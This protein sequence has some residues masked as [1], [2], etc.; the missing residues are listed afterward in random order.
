MF[1]IYRRAIASLIQERRRAAIIV[2]ANLVLGAVALLDPIVFGKVVGAVGRGAAAWP[3]IA[4]WAAVSALGV[5][6]GVTA[7]I[8]ADRLSHRRRLQAMT[9]AF[10]NAVTLPSALISERGTSRLVRIMTAG[11]DSL[12]WVLLGFL[13]EQM[14]ALFALALM[15][16]VAFWM[17]PGLAGVLV[18]LAGIYVAANLYVI[19]RT[20]SGQRSV[21]DQAQ[22]VSSR[23]GDVVAN[24]SVVQAYANLYSETAKLRQLSQQLLKAQFPVLNWWALLIVLTR[25]ASTIAL[26]SIY[27]V[28]GAMAAH[29]QSSL[30]EI[31]AFGGFATLL[32]G[33]LDLLSSSLSRLFVGLPTLKAFFALIDERQGFSDAPDARPLENARGEVAFEGVTHWICDRNDLGVFDLNVSV[34]AGA[35]VAL[36]GS[37]GAGK[38]TM[39]S[40]LQRIREPD[41]GRI[42]IDGRDLRETTLASLRASIAVVFQE[43]GLFNR[44]IGEN[45][46]MARP[47]ATD[48]E[49]Q[50]ALVAAEAWEFVQDK[51]GG[52]D[53]VIGERGQLLSGGERQRLAIARAIL[54][55]APILI[56]DEATSALDTVTEAKVKA[57]LDNA[58]RG[59]TTFV[60]AHRLSTIVD[61]DLILVLDKGRIVERGTF[62]D[63][64][65]QNGR[66]AHLAR[67][68]G[69]A[70]A[71]VIPLSPRAA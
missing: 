37:S 36:V 43:A 65:D 33:R 45:L 60:I 22:A 47:E 62:A 20:E 56:L 68:A 14:P 18:A 58:A 34:P 71:E 3:Y 9:E 59:R 52:L 7:S 64:V 51:E 19:R 11:G 55:N 1:S 39:M 32:I 29:G 44:S 35:T 6:A 23:I 13:R 2:G 70:P 28:G 5:G 40:L 10:D 54:K 42:T 8:V 69:L 21:D 63:L 50:A 12:F 30:G 61:A 49:L 57:A 24:V 66:F 48:A 17:N 15:I 25:S 38:T 67:E 41:L 46:R 53:F 31:V 4:A 27:A 16:P 26:V